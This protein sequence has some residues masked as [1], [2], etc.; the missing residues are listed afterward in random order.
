MESVLKFTNEWE[1]KREQLGYATDGVV[2]KVNE[3]Q[4]QQELD[5]KS[6]R[7]AIAYKYLKQKMLPHNY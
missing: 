4:N 6:P 5:A 1:T 7:W 3:Y 2:I